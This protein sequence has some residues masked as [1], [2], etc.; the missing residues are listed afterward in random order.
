MFIILLVLSICTNKAL[1]QQVLV[2]GTTFEPLPGN[3]GRAFIGANEIKQYGFQTGSL[4]ITPPITPSADADVFN[5]AFQYGITDNPY[6]LDNARYTNLAAAARDYQLVVSPATTSSANILEYKV[7]GMTPGSEVEV[8]VTYCNVISTTYT[9]CGPGEVTSLK[10]IINPDQYNLNNGLEGTQVKASICTDHVIKATV[11]GPN[12]NSN[13]V[14]ANGEIVFRLNTQQTGACKAVAIKKVEIYGVPKPKALSSQGS[15]VCAGEQITLQSPI[16]YNGT[17]QWQVKIGAGAWGNIPGGTNKAQLYETPGVGSYQFRVV[18]TPIPSGAAITSDPISVNAITCCE[19]GSPPVPA[20]RQTVYYDNFGRLDLSDKTGKSYIV[21][22][23]SD[24]LNPVE[25]PKTTTTPFRWPLVPAP[26]S[27]TFEGVAGEAPNDGEYTVAAYLTGFNFP[28]NGYDGAR[29]GWANRVTG[30]TAANI[31][32][33][34]LAYDHSGQPDGAALFLNCPTFT[35]GQI[36]YSRTIENL[37]FGKQLFFECWIAVFTNGPSPY[38]PVK[39]KVVLTDLDNAAGIP[40]EVTGT[41]T[42]QEDGGGVWV[43]IGAQIN[44]VGSRLKMDIIN[45][46]NV[47]ANGNDLVLD[48][49]KIMACSPPA[50]DLFFDL[51]TLS[52]STTICAPNN[53]PLY[54]KSTNLLKAYYNNNPL[55]LYQWSRTPEDFTSWTN[56]N[57]TPGTPEFY[58]LINAL[59]TTPF[60]GLPDGDKVY[61]RVIAATP[62]IFAAKNN[63]QGA[64]NHANLNDPCKN[65]SVS[66]AIEAYELCPLPIELLSFAAVSDGERN[67]LTWT[68]SWEKKQ[69]LFHY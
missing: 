67:K 65:Y 10:G 21:W 64:G 27:A 29:L 41:A 2:A 32:N 12:N 52:K 19:V 63:F 14:G 8:R 36:L 43:R 38:N 49:I 18:I 31:G 33:P 23:Y 55:Y 5:S 26:L 17:Y 56:M 35:Q 59:S 4:T 45:D 51:T 13:I 60:T 30:P 58:T 6:N 42:R 66:P 3:E 50:I 15:E 20:S 69:C 57:A 53:L 28:V 47:A 7:T 44:L 34:D 62:T 54:T 24:V 22:D 68:T 25:V 16:D 9:T 11:A 46:Q 40:V 1:G 48:D 37:C 39:I 61:F